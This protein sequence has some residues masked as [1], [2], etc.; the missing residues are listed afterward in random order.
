MVKSSAISK[1]RV[2]RSVYV[3][4]VGRLQLENKLGFFNLRG[5]GVERGRK[6]EGGEG[7]YPHMQT[8]LF[9]HQFLTN[10]HIDRFHKKISSKLG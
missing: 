6:E 2:T 3:L 8:Y 1:I 7:T 9:A 5:G 10:I 4:P